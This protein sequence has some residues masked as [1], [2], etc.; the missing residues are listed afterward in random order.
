MTTGMYYPGAAAIK[1]MP[2]GGPTHSTRGL[3]P[4]GLIA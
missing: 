2:D 1:P 4:I 3:A